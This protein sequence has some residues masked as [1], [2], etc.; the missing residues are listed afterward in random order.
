VRDYLY[1]EVKEMDL[2]WEPLPCNSG[3]F[4]MAD[5]SKCRDLI[6]KKYFETHEYDS[7]SEIL[8]TGIKFK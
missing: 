3:Y 1:K 5:I 2:P 6:P 7:P 8:K 4:L